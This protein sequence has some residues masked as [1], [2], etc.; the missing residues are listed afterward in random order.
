[1]GLFL[2]P[3]IGM[4]KGMIEMTEILSVCVCGGGAGMDTLTRKKCLSLA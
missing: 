1:M 2:V 3:R 4:G